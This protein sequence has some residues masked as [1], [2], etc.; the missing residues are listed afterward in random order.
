[1]YLVNVY[2]E[3]GLKKRAGLEVEMEGSSAYSRYLGAM[4]V[5]EIAQE[6]V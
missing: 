6:R 4:G 5:T 1:M 3:L 2:R